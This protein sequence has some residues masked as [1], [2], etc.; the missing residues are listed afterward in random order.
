MLHN[1]QIEL[2][3]TNVKKVC[4]GLGYRIKP[5]RESFLKSVDREDKD[6]YQLVPKEGVMKS[7]LSTDA[8]AAVTEPAAHPVVENCRLM[9]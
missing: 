7:V 6:S 2:K 4:A 9:T 5:D 1:L 3:I 8:E